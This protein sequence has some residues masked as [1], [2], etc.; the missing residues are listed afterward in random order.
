MT[1][2]RDY[3]QIPRGATFPAIGL[4]SSLTEY[5]D[6][7]ALAA[8]AL[9]GAVAQKD[10]H[11]HPDHLSYP[12]LFLVHHCLEAGLKEAITLCYSIC[13]TRGGEASQEPEFTHDLISVAKEMEAALQITPGFE[14]TALGKEHQEFLEALT[15][16]APGGE[17]LR[18]PYFNVRRKPGGD[19]SRSAVVD[20]PSVMYA[21][22]E[23]LGW[24][25]GLVSALDEADQVY[26]E[27]SR[28]GP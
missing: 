27:A 10:G 23:V 2:Q 25:V 17:V 19:L 11:P 20:I 4:L 14:G 5:A 7:Y 24:I 12:I 22:E 16:F 13:Q 18:Y 21:F 8:R 9:W 6:A 28:E 15:Q 3:P 1:D 26:W